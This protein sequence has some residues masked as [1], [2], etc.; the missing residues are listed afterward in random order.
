MSDLLEYKGYQGTVEYSTTDG[1]LYGKVIGITGLISYE[2]ESI[3]N[4]IEDFQGAID[5]YLEICADQGIEPQKAYKGK[6]NVRIPPELHKALVHFSASRGQTLNSSVEE[7][8]RQY[9]T[10]A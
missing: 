6:F 2:G 1:I 10:P 5:D 7:A 4:L 8:I 9:V 3:Q